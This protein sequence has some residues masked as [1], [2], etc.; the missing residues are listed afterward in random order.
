MFEMRRSPKRILL[1]CSLIAFMVASGIPA[2]I[3]GASSESLPS[4]SDGRTVTDSPLDLIIPEDEVYDLFGS[5]NY[6]RSI[7]INGTL[8]VTSYNGIDNSTGTLILKAPMITI[9][10]LGVIAAGGRGYGGGGGGTAQSSTTSLGGKGGKNGLGGNGAAPQASVTASGGGGG[11]N[12]GLGGVVT[13]Y[14]NGGAGTPFKGGDGGTYSSYTYSGKGG[15]GYGGGGGGGYSA[16]SYGGGGGGGGGTGGM[17][18]PEKPGAK[19][20]GPFGGNGGL[21]TSSQYSIILNAMNGG[22]LDVETNGETSPRD[23]NVYRGSG[24]GGGGAASQQTGGGGGGGAGGGSVS[25]FADQIL[26][27]SGAIYT[28]GGGGGAAGSYN[29]A[30]NALYV[31]GAGGGGAGGGIMLNANR[32]VMAGTLDARGMER[33]IPAMNNSGTIKIFYSQKFISGPCYSA[34]V[35]TNSKPK[36]NDLLEPES[37]TQTVVRPTFKWSKAYDEEENPVTYQV[38]VSTSPSFASIKL[39]RTGISGEQFTPDMPL[40][41][42]EFYWRVRA[43]DPFG[44]GPWSDTWKILVDSYPPKSVMD[45]LPEFMVSSTFTLSWT[46]LDNI[47]VWYYLVYYSDNAGP[48]QQWTKTMNTSCEFTG[49]DGHSYSF[50]SQAADT[51]DNLEGVPSLP[52]AQTTI[53]LSPP[54]TWFVNP[55]PFQNRPIFQV[56]WNGTDRTSGVGGYSIFASDNGGP[57]NLWM[58]NVPET[59]ALFRGVNSHEFS[60]YIIG[61]DLAGNVQSAPMP[62]DIWKTKV[63][64]SAPITSFMPSKPFFGTDPVYISTDTIISLGAAS[65]Y[66]GIRSTQYILDGNETLNFTRPFNESVPGLHNITIWSVDNT[67]NQEAP[68]TISFWVDAGTPTSSLAFIGPN[69]TR[70][71]TFYVSPDTMIFVSSSDDASGVNHV[72]MIVDGV[73]MNYQTPFKLTKGGLHTIR[74]YAVDN[75]GHMEEERTENVIVDI[76]PPST[77]PDG[78]TGMQRRTVKITLTGTDLESGFAQYYFRITEKGDTPM[79]FTPGSEI[80]LSARDDHSTDGTFI[81]DYYGVDNVGNQAAFK[82]VEVTIDTMASMTVDLKPSVTVDQNTLT[83]KGTAEPGASLLINGKFVLVKNDGTFSYP[84]ELGRG[85]NKIVISMTDAAGN[86]VSETH[87]ATYTPSD[88]LPPWFIPLAVVVILAVATAICMM[89]FMRA[90]RVKGAKF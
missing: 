87:F 13:T 34:M 72:S 10:P 16:S 83:V 45:P 25:L 17:D 65:D 46:G 80:L 35:F 75:V 38:Q 23:L 61:R 74:C 71:G 58:A 36:M 48:Y 26:S 56:S 52:D 88:E 90:R 30:T 41:G 73:P 29:S 40:L 44:A 1:S 49:Q 47:A 24:G 39:D 69:F 79:G 59:T 64:A 66:S 43:S 20:G 70:E 9:G 6:T 85:R 33:N 54:E 15:T 89:A 7:Q 53:D 22:Y 4:G 51:S 31:G 19:G 11:S 42:K 2:G 67:G 3:C 86:A 12:G 63:D 27:I 84:V 78:P 77:L 68:N 62:Q 32:V 60:F 82:S 5:H 8:N 37:G 18:S 76:W 57:F 50:Y 14:G 55:A 21:T 81:V 28:R